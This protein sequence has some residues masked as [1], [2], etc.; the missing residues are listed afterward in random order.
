MDRHPT[1]GRVVPANLA[2]RQ[3]RLNRHWV[4]TAPAERGSGAPTHSANIASMG[5]RQHGPFAG[6]AA[7]LVGTPA[8]IP[9]TAADPLETPVS[10]RECGKR[11]DS[12]GRAG[13]L[14]A[15][16]LP[17]GFHPEFRTG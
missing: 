10:A 6:A 12:G 13:S 14:R 7:A 17:S 5:I 15:A 3:A 1:P 9:G 11:N 16:N 4:R 2:C 8:R